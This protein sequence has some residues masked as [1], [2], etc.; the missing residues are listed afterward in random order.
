LLYIL[1]ATRFE[2]PLRMVSQTNQTSGPYSV[3]PRGGRVINRFWRGSGGISSARTPE[4]MRR[5]CERPSMSDT[6]ADETLPW[7]SLQTLRHTTTL[8][9]A[10]SMLSIASP[11]AVILV[12]ERSLVVPALILVLQRESTKVWGVHADLE[13]PVSYV[14]PSHRCPP[15]SFPLFTFSLPS[16]YS[17]T[18]SSTAASNFA[19]SRSAH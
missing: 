3:H 5:R 4:Q 13:D 12:A 19:D 10:I 8:I 15:S 16:P 18:S 7:C 17:L 9:R 6:K 1:P 14:E 2:I 11:E